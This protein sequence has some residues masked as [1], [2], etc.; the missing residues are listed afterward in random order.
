MFI[1]NFKH[2]LRALPTEK[3]GHDAFMHHI[4]NTEPLIH[5]TEEFLERVTN[6]SLAK[7][8]APISK[9]DHNPR[10]L[11]CAFAMTR[12]PIES[13]RT[14]EQPL[15]L[16]LLNKAMNLLLAIDCV[17]H[18]YG[19]EDDTQEDFLSHNN[20]IR[21]LHAL[22]EYRAMWAEWCAV[23]VATVRAAVVTGERLVVH[24]PELIYGH[25]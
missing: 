25:E 24:G 12:F 4:Q 7:V 15:Q 6:Y 8:H 17:V 2:A 5:S 11:L 23:E 21:F 3:D 22:G 19:V 9:S 13:L 10:I 1:T 16:T 18:E 14:P 20:A